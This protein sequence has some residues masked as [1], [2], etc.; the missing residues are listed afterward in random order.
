MVKPDECAE[1]YRYSLALYLTTIPENSNIMIVY[2]YIISQF[3]VN[4]VFDALNAC[5]KSIIYD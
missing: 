4:N 2:R 1:Q 3:Y 5:C